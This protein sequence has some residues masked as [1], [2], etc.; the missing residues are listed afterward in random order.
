MKDRRNLEEP[1][2]FHPWMKELDNLQTFFLFNF[3]WVFFNR[4]RSISVFQIYLS[5]FFPSLQTHLQKKTPQEYIWNE[6]NHKTLHKKKKNVYIYNQP[7]ENTVLVKEQKKRQ[8]K[9][10]FFIKKKRGEIPSL[11]CWKIR[12]FFQNHKEA[13]KK[14]KKRQQRVLNILKIILREESEVSIQSP[15]IYIYAYAVISI[16]N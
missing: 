14:R 11:D 7:L 13:K 4:D 9:I 1:L 15:Y 12:F 10:E 3:R 16:R 5:F 6:I 2:H 8:T